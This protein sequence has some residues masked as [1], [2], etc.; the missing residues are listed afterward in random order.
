MRN[1]FSRVVSIC[2]GSLLIGLGLNGF[3]A[4]Y[5][6]LDGGLI[7]FGLIVYYVFGTPVGLS[8]FFLNVPVYLYAFF[9]HRQNF[10]YGSIGLFVSFFMTEWLSV[11]EGTLE[12]PLLFS[13]LLGGALVGMGIGLMLR[14]GISSD[15]LDLIAIIVSKKWKINIGITIFILDSTIMIVGLHIIGFT[16]FCY[17]MLVITMSS[18]MIMLFTSPRWL[19]S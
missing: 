12:L 9:R 7:G 14:Y 18:I 5:H 10:F 16:A 11:L 17:S 3:I 19:S 13:S 6:L 4:P 15:G 2:C 1:I 8:I